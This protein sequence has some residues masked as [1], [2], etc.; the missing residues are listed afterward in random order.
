MAKKLKMGYF[1]RTL[2]I[3]LP[4]KYKKGKNGGR[5]KER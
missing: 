3:H 4:I 5:K 2:R 1:P